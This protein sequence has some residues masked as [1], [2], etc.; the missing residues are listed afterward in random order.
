V[1]RCGDEAAWW[2]KAHIDPTETA[3]ALWLKTHPLPSTISPTGSK[4]RNE[5]NFGGA[6]HDL[7]SADRSQPA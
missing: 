2:N 1:H 4:L 5:P 3:R 6:P 7:V